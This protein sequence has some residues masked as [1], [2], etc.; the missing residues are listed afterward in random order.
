[1][2]TGLGVLETRHART[3]THTA[4]YAHSSMHKMKASARNTTHMVMAMIQLLERC[5]RTRAGDAVRWVIVARHAR[6]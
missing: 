5:M 4:R 1:M 2:G 6:A 3:D